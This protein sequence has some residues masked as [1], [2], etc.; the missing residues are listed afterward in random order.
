MV[1]YG[2]EESFFWPRK[3]GYFKRAKVFTSGTYRPWIRLGQL[4]WDKIKFLNKNE[5]SILILSSFG[6]IIRR[7]N[8]IY[9]EHLKD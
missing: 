5:V 1:I 2:L 8:L 9:V 4:G 6:L 3:H 7:R